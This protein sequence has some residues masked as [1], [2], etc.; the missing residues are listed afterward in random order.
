MNHTKASMSLMMA[1]TASGDMLPPYVV[2]KSLHLYDTRVKNG[3]ENTRYNRS[4]PAWFEGKLF[5]DWVLNMVIPY[6]KIK[7]A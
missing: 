1:G 3:P 5:D 2:Y 4:S 6:F 7:N